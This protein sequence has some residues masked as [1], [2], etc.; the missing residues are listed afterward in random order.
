MGCQSAI[1]E[2]IVSRKSNCILALKENQSSL[3]EQVKDE[4]SFLKSETTIAYVDYGHCR[5]ETRK[6]SVTKDFK[7][8]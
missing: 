5:I 2:Q 8:L 6:C 1:T 7:H 4:F 3:L